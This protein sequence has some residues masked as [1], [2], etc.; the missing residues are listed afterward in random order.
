M[1]EK[2][3]SLLDVLAESAGCAF[4][5]DLRNLNPDQQGRL[6]KKQ[7]GIPPEVYSLLVWNDALCYLLSAPVELTPEAARQRLIDYYVNSE[8]TLLQPL[9]EE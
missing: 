3:E 2:R 9:S 8:D 6:A 4:L 1:A 7:E 5:S